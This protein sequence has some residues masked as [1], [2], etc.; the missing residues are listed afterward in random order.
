MT[1]GNLILALR[2]MLQDMRKP[3]GT[4]IITA[5]ESGLRWSSSDLI[6]KCNNALQE[7]SRLIETYS[8]SP[9][10]LQLAEFG[11]MAE[12][13]F[14]LDDDEY[15]YDFDITTDKVLAIQ[16]LVDVIGNEYE[17]ISPERYRAFQL[18]GNEQIGDSHYFT[19]M[20]AAPDYNQK[21][22]YV[23]PIPSADATVFSYVATVK[24][25]PYTADYFDT[26][27]YIQGID[28]FI[29]E[30]AL[31]NCRLEERNME[32]YNMLLTSIM[33]KLGVAQK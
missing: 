30:V 26:E 5:D 9:I 21:R 15:Y 11:L 19:V 6:D 31:K 2:R 25:T 24:P 23:L 17:Y 22:I 8:K 12:G 10:A 28:D 13:N 33:L 20:R 4:I 3:N 29:L 18:T 16:G 7:T 27:I 32:D 1:F 14:S